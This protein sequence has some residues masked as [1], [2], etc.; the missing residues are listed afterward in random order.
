LEWQTHRPSLLVMLLYIPAAAYP[1]YLGAEGAFGSHWPERSS[2]WLALMVA[3]LVLSI[4]FAL[5][6]LYLL[7]RFA[8]LILG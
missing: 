3:L 8:L 6:N 1:I 4:L 7:V 5:W 2:V